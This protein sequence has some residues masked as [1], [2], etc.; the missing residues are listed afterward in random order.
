MGLQK[1]VGKTVSMVCHPCQASGNITMAVYWRRIMVEGDYYR[2][3]QRYRVEY[4]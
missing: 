2:E 1:N 3:R 4:E